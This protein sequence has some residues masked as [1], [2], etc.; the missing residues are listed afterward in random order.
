MLSRREQHNKKRMLWKLEPLSMKM[1][2]EKSKVGAKKSVV[3]KNENFH[4]RRNEE[5]LI[6]P[7]TLSFNT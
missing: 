2:N 6:G 4:W 5:I 1:T 3:G 7:S